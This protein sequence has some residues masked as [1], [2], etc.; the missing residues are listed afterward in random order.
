MNQ[1]TDYKCYHVH[2]EHEKS[3]VHITFNYI[4]LMYSLILKKNK[5]ASKYP[6][7][8]ATAYDQTEKT[9]F[10]TR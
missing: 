3:Y 8:Y 7:Y 1:T 5:A 2:I 9:Y 4:Q 10:V 6:K